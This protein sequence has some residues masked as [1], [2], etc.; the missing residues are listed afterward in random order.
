MARSVF[1]ILLISS[2]LFSCAGSKQRREEK[3]RLALESTASYHNQKAVELIDSC[4]YSQAIEHLR[5]AIDIV[6][7]DPQTFN[8]LGSAFYYLGEMD[9]AKAMYQQ[10]I[11]LRPSFAMAYSNLAQLYFKQKQYDEA[12]EAANNALHYDASRPEPVI[13]KAKVY[14][15]NE[16]YNDAINLYIEYIKL[17]P[18]ESAFVVNLAKLYYDIGLLDESVEMYK[19]ALLLEPNNPDLYFNLGNVFFQKCKLDDARLAYETATQ[20]APQMFSALNNYGLIL[21]NLKEYDKALE[22]F[23]YALSLEADSPIILFNL[24]ITWDRLED[25]QKSYDYINKAIQLDS[26]VSVFFMQKGNLLLK[27]DHYEQAI[28]EFNQALRLNS[29]LAMAYNNLGSAFLKTNRVDE[30]IAALKKSMDLYHET[31]EKG[32][33]APVNSRKA[34]MGN[35]LKW[36]SEPQQVYNEMAYLYI[37]LGKSYLFINQQE[38]AKKYFLNAVNLAPHLAEPFENLGLIFTTEKNRVLANNSFARSRINQGNDYMEMDSLQ[39]AEQLYNE[40]LRF[41][42]D[43]PEALARLGLV[44]QQTNRTKN[45]ATLLQKALRNAPQDYNVLM[46]YGDYRANLNFWPEAVDFYEQALQKAPE[47]RD[48]LQRLVKASA[49]LNNNQ[50]EKLYQAKIHDLNGKALEFAGLLDPALEEY[51]LAAGTDSTNT[52]YLNHIG[53]IFTKKHL[54]QKAEKIFRE[55]LSYQPQNPH[56]LL[57]M[58]TV[59]GDMQRYET[60]IDYLNRSAQADPDNAQTHYILAVNYY[61]LKNYEQA[62]QHLQLAASLGMEVNQ[63]FIERMEQK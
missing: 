29:N 6:P 34:D 7:Y 10:A 19:K 24:S 14:T 22:T 21:V 57:G 5:E 41:Q 38:D 31:I 35:L 26:S 63:D 51:Q 12:L 48:I 44:H 53:F 13:I 36:C 17:Y 52:E 54:N 61:F 43:F 2:L 59:F 8:N 39:V 47:S 18:R 46:L 55:V 32:I 4:K 15:E 49:I 9:S 40:A 23:H 1:Y 45:A 11:R 27:T 20:I 42:P 33:S 25:L 50:K 37:N 62:K 58:G 3:I 60:A 28:Q 16:L 30:S 56:A